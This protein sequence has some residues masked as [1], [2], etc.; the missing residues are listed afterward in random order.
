MLLKTPDDQNNYQVYEPEVI[1]AAM[2]NYRRFRGLYFEE[3]SAD[4]IEDLSLGV[5]DWAEARNV[6]PSG[7]DLAQT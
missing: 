7:L 2:R 6:I 1:R 5:R 3:T 4:E